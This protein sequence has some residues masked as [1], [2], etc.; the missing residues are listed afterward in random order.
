MGNIFVASHAFNVLPSQTL[1]KFS[2]VHKYNIN[3]RPINMNET[4][5]KKRKKKKRK[6]EKVLSK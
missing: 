2:P 3:H 5:Q 4:I 6:K 1:F